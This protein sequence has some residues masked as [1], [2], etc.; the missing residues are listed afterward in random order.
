MNKEWSELNKQ[1]QL[2]LKKKDTY[3]DG[4][5]KLIGL[6]NSIMKVIVSFKDE[7]T[8]DELAA[9]PFPN[10]DGNHSTTIAWAL[11]HT[12]RIEDTVVHTLINDDEQVFFSGDWQRRMNSPIITTANELTKAEMTRFSELLDTDG[13]FGYISEVSKN[14]ERI[15]NALPYERLKEK[16]PP[17]RREKLRKL[18]VVSGHED[19]AWL[20]DYWC[21]KDI[22]GLIYMPLSRHWIMHTEACLRIKEKLK[23]EHQT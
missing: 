16:I 7:I 8:R 14:T 22:K 21:G 3:R 12:F 2:L 5:G 6:R 19:A 13:L 1:M 18:N 9:M 10:A 11:W 4:I 17:E 15:L 23:N 20:I